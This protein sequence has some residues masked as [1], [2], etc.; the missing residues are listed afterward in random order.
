MLEVV[1]LPTAPRLGQSEQFADSPTEFLSCDLFSIKDVDLIFLTILSHAWFGMVMGHVPYQAKSWK[2]NAS[3][4]LS[5]CRKGCVYHDTAPFKSEWWINNQKHRVK[6]AQAQ[7]RKDSWLAA[8]S[9]VVLFLPTTVA[10]DA[11]SAVHERW[12]CIICWPDL[13]H[14]V[15]VGDLV[16]C[17]HYSEGGWISLC[18]VPAPLLT[19]PVLCRSLAVV[20]CWNHMPSQ[21][22]GRLF[23]VVTNDRQWLFHCLFI[24]NLLMAL[25]CLLR[26]IVSLIGNAALYLPLKKDS[27]W[28][29]VQKEVWPS[30]SWCACM[31][32]KVLVHAGAITGVAWV[33]G[34]VV[35][36]MMCARTA[37]QK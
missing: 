36:G 6:A 27:N 35:V 21:C 13:C 29:V 12:V 14:S 26:H 9:D 1:M 7:S 8:S 33:K 30:W 10:G 37:Y 3:A 15:H 11:L 4:V 23:L 34:Q 22:F 5:S 32:L 25:Q 28:R 31:L 19:S 24:S 17:W 2:W 18:D 16:W 20:G